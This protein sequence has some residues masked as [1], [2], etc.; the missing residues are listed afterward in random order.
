MAL[1]RI[2]SWLLVV[3]AVLLLLWF[4]L[5][6]FAVIFL[7]GFDGHRTFFFAGSFFY[8]LIAHLLFFGSYFACPAL[9]QTTLGALS[10]LFHS[11]RALVLW[12]VIYAIA[13]SYVFYVIY[14]VNA[15]RSQS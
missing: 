8:L 15:A 12:G 7:P 11:R 1:R 14:F 5:A 10:R 2:L 3:P 13:F 6:V 9:H 4:V